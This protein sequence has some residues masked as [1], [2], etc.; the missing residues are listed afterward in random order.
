METSL[1]PMTYVPETDTRFWYQK[2]DTKIWYQKKLVPDCLTHLPDSGISFL[3]PE[4]GIGFW[5]VCHG[6]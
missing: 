1:M 5:Y 4:S 3:V 2:T 6:H